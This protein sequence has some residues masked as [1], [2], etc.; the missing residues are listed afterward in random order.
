MQVVNSLALKS[1]T[2]LSK[3]PRLGMPVDKQGFLQLQITT[4]AALVQH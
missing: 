3:I 2:K 1:N 4:N